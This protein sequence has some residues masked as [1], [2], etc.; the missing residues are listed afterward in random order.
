MVYRQAGQATEAER[1]H[2]GEGGAPRSC[3]GARKYVAQQ[4]LVYRACRQQARQAGWHP[5][6]TR[7]AA[8]RRSQSTGSVKQVAPGGG[9]CFLFFIAPP[10]ARHACR[11]APPPRRRLLRLPLIV[12]TCHGQRRRADG[13]RRVVHSVWVQPQLAAC[14][15][16]ELRPRHL[17]GMVQQ[18]VQS[19]VQRGGGGR[20]RHRA[21]QQQLARRHLAA[22]ESLQLAKGCSGSCLVSIMPCKRHF[23]SAEIS[24]MPAALNSSALVPTTQSASQRPQPACLVDG[25]ACGQHRALQ[26][27][28]SVQA[29]RSRVRVDHGSA[30][31]SRHCAGRSGAA[32]LQASGKRG[33][34]DKRLRDCCLP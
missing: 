21:R 29:S 23:H 31:H 7:P 16:Q 11:G 14:L 33:G 20:S 22:V 3:A 9:R 2:R 5:A 17:P 30:V 10:P 26:G 6:V 19:S 4:S 25:V 8:D 27:Q 13:W 32:H 18:S 12:S 34:R 24:T 28:P 15:P 1:T